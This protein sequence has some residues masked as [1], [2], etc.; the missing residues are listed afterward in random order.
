[1]KERLKSLVLGIL[2]GVMIGLGGL[3][4]VA[5]L[6][7]ETTGVGRI[8][9]SILFACGLLGVCCLGLFLYT[10]KIGY[11]FQNKRSFALDLLFGYAG[12][13]IGAL[14]LGFAVYMVNGY[15]SGPMGATFASIASSRELFA[16]GERWY[17]SLILS[18]ICGILVFAGVDI[19]KKK[20]GAVG[21]IAL[22]LCVAVFVVTGTEHTVANMFYFAAGGKWSAGAFLNILFTTIGNSLGSLF[23]ERLLFLS[24]YLG[25]KKEEVGPKE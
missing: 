9:G 2:A 16:G 25:K 11:L 22:I 5:C 20:G 15:A 6:S 13:V 4:Y 14:L 7:Y 8:L 24:E 1:M 19:F 10:G 12:N 18:F 3:A 21:A 17:D 23:V